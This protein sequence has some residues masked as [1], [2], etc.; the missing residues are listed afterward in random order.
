[1]RGVRFGGA[2]AAVYPAC[3]RAQE[4]GIPVAIQV[5]ADRLHE[6]RELA[7]RFPSV[8][9]ILDHLAHPPTADGPPYAAAGE[10]FALRD[11]TNVHFKFSSMN[12][13]EAAEGKSTTKAF[14]GALVEHFG[15]GRLLWGS[16]FPHSRGS[17]SA[18]YKDLVDLAREALAFLPAAEREQMLAGTAHKL[19]PAL[20]HGGHG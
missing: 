20:V 9:G 15:S 12:L 19:F 13:W 7:E 1:M 6:V 5:T 17:A 4:L 18:P 14:L 16:D 3:E 10:F 11:L 8:N 2:E